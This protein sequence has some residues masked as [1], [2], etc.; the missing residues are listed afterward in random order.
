MRL[1]SPE[2]HVLHIASTRDP[3]GVHVSLAAQSSAMR[4]HAIVSH[5]IYIAKNGH[6]VI[7]RSFEQHEVECNV[8]GSRFAALVKLLET[9]SKFVVR[10]KCPLVVHVH[11]GLP[12][13]TRGMDLLR[14]FA[15]FLQIPVVATLHG[16]HEYLPI[17]DNPSMWS[18]HIRFARKWPA[19]TVPSAEQFQV[20]KGIC[21]DGCTALQVVPNA[22]VNCAKLEGRNWKESKI[23]VTLDGAR[24][25]F[26]VGRL[27]SEKNCGALI[28]A[29]AILAR[30]DPLVQLVCIGD[31]PERSSLE[32]AARRLGPGIRDRI[33]FAGYVESPMQLLDGNCVFASLSRFESFGLVAFEAA[34]AGAPLVL[35]SIA[36]WSNWFRNGADCFLVA[37]DDSEGAAFAIER[38]LSDSV[39]RKAMVSNAKEVAARVASP[40]VIGNAWRKLYESMLGSQCWDE[41]RT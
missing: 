20:Q 5:I 30:R 39:L 29:F 23:K 1:V 4:E 2:I 24:R 35:S 41:R 17:N 18:R 38:L 34:M 3:G 36:P 11:S 33:E 16:A 26:F 28:S 6:D 27:A 13:I 22:I 40:D 25:I 15:S 7:R 12:V 32:Q 14:L 8:F 21:G 10:R 19:I 31:G 37:P 9:F